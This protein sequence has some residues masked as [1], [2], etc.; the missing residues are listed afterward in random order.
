[1]WGPYVDT[2]LDWTLRYEWY[3]AMLVINNGYH[4]NT[5]RGEIGICVQIIDII[6]GS[7]ANIIGSVKVVT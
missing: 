1:M 7:V 3:M 4:E 5:C 2:L 6:L